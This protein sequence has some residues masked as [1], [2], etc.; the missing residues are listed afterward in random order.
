MGEI[1]DL[2]EADAR[3]LFPL[4]APRREIECKAVPRRR[5]VPRRRRRRFWIENDTP[6]VTGLLADDV[7]HELS[8]WLGVELPRR[9]RPRL[10]VLADMVYYHNRQFRQ[11][12]RGKGRR[13]V[14]YLRAFMQH[15]LGSL[16]YRWRSAQSKRF[17]EFGGGSAHRA[18]GPRTEAWDTLHEV[19]P[20]TAYDAG[21]KTS[22]LVRPALR[23]GRD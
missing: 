7:C 22:R 17:A 8:L 13:G 18:L 2:A 16:L 1:L 12:V 19:P 21:N 23:R 4:P 9:W 6:I 11:R 15:W 20:A 10:V 5:W 14:N 3:R